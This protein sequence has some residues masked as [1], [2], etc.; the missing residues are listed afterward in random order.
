MPFPDSESSRIILGRNFIDFLTSK[1]E[2]PAVR[3]ND[4]S[5]SKTAIEG[6]LEKQWVIESYLKD[7]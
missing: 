5:F 4:L 1:L 2:S 6:V 7:S 3:F